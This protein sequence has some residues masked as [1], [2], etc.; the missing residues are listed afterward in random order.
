[1][2]SVFSVSLINILSLSMFSILSLT[3]YILFT[4]FSH[5]ILSPQCSLYSLNFLLLSLSVFSHSTR[6]SR[7]SLNFLLLSSGQSFHLEWHFIFSQIETRDL[8]ALNLTCRFF[9]T[10]LDKYPPLTWRV[11]CLSSL[12]QRTA[13]DIGLQMS[14]IQRMK[15][16]VRL[17]I[18]VFN[19]GNMLSLTDLNLILENLSSLQALKLIYCHLLSDFPTL[20]TCYPR[21]QSLTVFQ[22]QLNAE[23][24]SST[25]PNLTDC[26]IAG[27]SK[28]KISKDESLGLHLMDLRHLT[29]LGLGDLITSG[30]PLNLEAISEFPKLSHLYLEGSTT[31]SDAHFDKPAKPNLFPSGEFSALRELVLSESRVTESTEAFKARVVLIKALDLPFP[32]ICNY[33]WSIK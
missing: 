2:F 29:K 18:G 5:S 4:L 1:M 23:N 26:I 28:V 24:L 7:Y 6:C 8:N 27:Q 30:G 33:S 3:D 9:R 15:T 12:E 25:F 13:L 21:L 19:L 32:K 17:E 20:G 22:T 14:S 10:V 16:I 31:K 11:A